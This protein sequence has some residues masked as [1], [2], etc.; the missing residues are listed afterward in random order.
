MKVQSKIL[1][2][3][4]KTQV[5]SIVHVQRQRARLSF[6]SLTPWQS[7]EFFMEDKEGL[8]YYI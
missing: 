7:T 3:M 2:F 8:D 6:L 4:K 1:T 5:I